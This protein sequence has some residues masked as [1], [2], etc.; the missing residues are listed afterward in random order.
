M[1]GR[2]L[3]RLFS[4]VV[5][6]A[7]SPSVSGE[8]LVSKPTLNLV[9]QIGG[10]IQGVAVRDS[11]AYVTVGPRLLVME[12]SEA[13]A[14][15]ELGGSPALNRFLTD[16]V[17]SGSFAYVAAGEA[18]V[19]IIDVADP[20]HPTIVGGWDSPGY[21]EAV[22]VVGNTLYVADGPYGLRTVDVKD[23][24][25]PVEIGWAFP[26][27]YA[28]DVAVSDD[29]AV[30]ASV[31][32][33]LFVA[34]VSDPA[35]PVET[36]FLKTNG[37]AFG[38]AIDGDIAYVANGWGGLVPVDISRPWS[39]TVLASHGTPG[40][41]MDVAVG[42]GIAMVADGFMG[43]RVVDVSV[44]ADPVDISALG[45]QGLAVEV[46]VSGTKAYVV[47]KPSE[48]RVIDISSV[49]TPVEQN[50]FASIGP[51]EGV[52]VHGDFAYLASGPRGLQVVDVSI[53]SEPKL[54]TQMDT[55]GDADAVSV[56]G[57]NAYVVTSD[58]PEGLDIIDVSDPTLPSRTSFLA[59][60]RMAFM[61]VEVQ[62]G[63]A[64][65]PDERGLAAV[66]VSDPANPVEVG[67]KNLETIRFRWATHGVGVSGSLAAVSQ[68]ADGVVFLDVSDPE[69]M[70]VLSRAEAEWAWDVTLRGDLAFIADRGLRIVDI[71]DPEKTEEVGFAPSTGAEGRD[72]VLDG[73][74]AYMAASQ[75]GVFAYDISDP[76]NP[77]QVDEYDTLGYA[78]KVAFQDG[79]IYVAD[80]EGGL[81][82]LETITA[83]TQI[84]RSYQVTVD[85]SITKGPLHS[86]SGV[87]HGSG[88]GHS[89]K[90]EFSERSSF[91]PAHSSS[92][93]PPWAFQ[94]LPAENPSTRST[95]TSAN[96]GNYGSYK[97]ARAS[98]N[99]AR[100]LASTCVVETSEDSGSGSLRWCL[101]QAQ[102]GDS[103]V[104]DPAVFPPD[105]PA[106]I[107]LSSV[108][109]PITQGGLMIDA[110]DSGVI[111]D[112]SDLSCY[113]H[114]FYVESDENTFRGLQIYG[115][116]GNAFV[117][118]GS[119]NVIGGS[120]SIGAG[121]VGQG[122]V[123]SGNYN[124]IG[125][126]H[127]SG[128]NI[129]KGNLIGTDVTG[130]LA[131]GNSS[132]GIH[133]FGHDN[134]IGGT[135]PGERNIAS[136]NGEAGIA[137]HFSSSVGNRVIG[138]YVGTDIDGMVALGN[139][140]YGIG[141]EQGPKGNLI[142]GNLCSGNEQGI[143]FVD[144]G[145]SFNSVVGNVV[146]LDASGT[147]ALGNRREGIYLGFGSAWLNRVGGTSPEDRNIIS[148]NLGDGIVVAGESQ[149]VLGNF[150]GTDITGTR[151]IGN[152]DG[153][154]TGHSAHSFVGGTS[155]EERNVISGNLG[156][157]IRAPLSSESMFIGNFIGVDPT[158]TG[159]L[160]NGV[161]VSLEPG[162]RRMVF[163]SNVISGNQGGV[164][165]GEGSERILLRAN[166]IGVAA[167]DLAPIPNQ[168]EG[169]RIESA[170]NQIGG[171]YP[172]DGNIIAH[173]EGGGV[174]V[175]T[176]SGNT[177]LGNSIYENNGWGIDLANGA[178]DS[179]SAPV[180]TQAISN[181]VWGSTCPNCCVDVFSDED[182][183]GGVYE[184]STGADASGSFKFVSETR[185]HGPHITCTA[186]DE[187]G[188]TSSFSD[189]T[190]L[191]LHRRP[192]NR[193]TP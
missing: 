74:A 82:I 182:D 145:S 102:S 30:I 158:G 5:V 37:C 97:K 40:W 43:L 79:L 118:G 119:R 73:S 50:S 174:Q 152:G 98:T 106:T 171:P 127:G 10:P 105:E 47:D 131:K 169:V 25:N 147:R 19:G 31:T 91:R 8:S 29:V 178:N 13:G 68:S 130:K 35:H 135:E 2:L 187:D 27:R 7:L 138:N 88:T 136:A 46:M 55:E 62:D 80:W 90:E 64:F 36:G 45:F 125:M 180:I 151:S 38:V 175:R 104:F 134:L 34:N 60:R 120:R 52:A 113:S 112:G 110:S 184:G 123:L 78:E 28:I 6:C 132:H 66:D 75:A 157:G 128:E 107:L 100:M 21:A 4:L 186:T 39:P 77:L 116:C 165:I 56:V 146:G 26:L 16:V 173:N 181:S 83:D 93:K 144:Q 53:P 61:D 76:S 122:N 172:G 190:S 168:R 129:I 162:A 117:I 70:S 95:E 89:E 189:P 18:G 192:R 32:A 33:G 143:I 44:P 163:Q 133:V 153:I 54:V 101:E 103:I 154:S 81:V 99:M 48:L 149:L 160:P 3:T 166:R 63:F 15:I 137:L 114:G 179:K 139:V 164:E 108:L 140:R 11:I 24:S 59:K 22:V 156:R 124:G 176:G 57:D 9:G 85:R 17:V 49:L 84:A 12:V 177:I 41:A 92:L 1:A 67:W 161:A 121:P 183:Q 20:T 155:R 142:Q 109:P 191:T 141:A 126:D 170:S 111:L 86:Q 87:G 69:Q 23:A 148:G 150:I 72:V 159:P 185:L 58:G 193:V 65:L 115:F 96:R 94:T 188:N 51:V 14:L 42:D 71:S 167:E